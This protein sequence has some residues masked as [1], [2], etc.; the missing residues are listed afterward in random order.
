[1]PSHK[2]RGHKKNRD[3]RKVKELKY[4]LKKSKSLSRSN[5]LRIRIFWAKN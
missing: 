1:M 5:N 2:R 4:K 3:S